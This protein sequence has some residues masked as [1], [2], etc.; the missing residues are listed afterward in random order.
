MCLVFGSLA[1][2]G[3]NARNVSRPPAGLSALAL[4]EGGADD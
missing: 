2:I 1:L 3:D 4:D